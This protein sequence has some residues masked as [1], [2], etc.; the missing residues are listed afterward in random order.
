MTILFDG[1]HLTSD[2]SADELHEFA[3]GIGMK[4]S[5]YQDKGKAAEHPHYDVMGATRK[6]AVGRAVGRVSSVE[7]LCRSWWATPE[8]RERWVKMQALAPDRARR[9]RKPAS[10]KPQLTNN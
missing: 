5:W 10:A 1:V 9:G 2:T 3:V 4:R 7:L 8:N 6:R